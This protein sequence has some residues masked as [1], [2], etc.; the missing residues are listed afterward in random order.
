MPQWIGPIGV[1][2][3]DLQALEK[4]L[5]AASNQA[6]PYW[7]IALTLLSATTDREE[8]QYWNVRTE[9][10]TPAACDPSWRFLGYDVSD[11][12]LLSGLTNLSWGNGSK[13]EVQDMYE[14]YSPS[15][16][17]YHLF[18][19]VEP[20][21]AFIPLAEEGARAHAPFFVFGIWLIRKEEGLPI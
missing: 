7:V 11:R 5:S 17:E 16:N 19:S 15:L 1:I 4:A 14:K 12:Y 9:G 10:V 8:Q 18:T 13:E 2:W 20:A 6:K 21:A 3:E